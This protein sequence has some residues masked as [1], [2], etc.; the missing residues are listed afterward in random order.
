MGMIFF[1]CLN[2]FSWLPW[3]ENRQREYLGITSFLFVQIIYGLSKRCMH[4]CKCYQFNQKG[5]WIIIIVIVIIAGEVE[6]WGRGVRCGVVG[7]WVLRRPFKDISVA[8]SRYPEKNTW[9]SVSSSSQW[10]KTEWLTTRRWRPIEI[11]INPSAFSMAKVQWSH[12]E[13]Y[14]ATRIECI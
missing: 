6:R 9:T 14:R 8:S 7:G 10:R 3:Q 2:H 4:T 1:S 12:S 11:C 13:S 5:I